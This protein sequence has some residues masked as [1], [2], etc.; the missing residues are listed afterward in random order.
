MTFNELTLGVC[1]PS[2]CQTKSIEK[3]VKVLFEDGHLGNLAEADITVDHCQLAGASVEY[4]I[5]YY[6]AM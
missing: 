4:A 6:I 5:G 1:M 3:F 2:E